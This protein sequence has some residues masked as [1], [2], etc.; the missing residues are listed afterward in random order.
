[1]SEDHI[2]KI[3][4]SGAMSDRCSRCAVEP[5]ILSRAEDWLVR[6]RGDLVAD[7]MQ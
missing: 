4:R 5:M 3:H 7:K 1:M 6:E 2:E